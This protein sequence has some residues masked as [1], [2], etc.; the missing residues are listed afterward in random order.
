ME[1]PDPTPS[2]QRARREREAARRWRVERWSDDQCTV[3]GE[4]T[5][6]HAP[7]A[8]LAA[9]AKLGITRSSEQ[10]KIRCYMIEPGSPAAPEASAVREW[11]L[12][13]SG[14]GDNWG[15]D[16]DGSKS[17]TREGAATVAATLQR[18][19]IAEDI[20][21]VVI[22]YNKRTGQTERALDL[23]EPAERHLPHY[24]QHPVG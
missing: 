19:L 5:A 13:I 1:H 10:L 11:E 17:Y 9:Y 21:A 14:A 20:P 2:G 23:L 15:Q 8:N 18:L 3:L 22:L 24:W 6:P 7:G 12:T 16:V 4:V